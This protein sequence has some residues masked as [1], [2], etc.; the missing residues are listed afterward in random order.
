[1]LWVVNKKL[2]NG[3][4]QKD[5][6]NYITRPNIG[7]LHCFLKVEEIPQVEDILP[8]SFDKFAYDVS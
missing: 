4:F 5:R 1:M 8:L 6:V 2:S 3:R 7:G